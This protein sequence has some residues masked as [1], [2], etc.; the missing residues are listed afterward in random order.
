MANPVIVWRAATARTGGTVMLQVAEDLFREAGLD[1]ASIEA[2]ELND[3]FDQSSVPVDMRPAFFERYAGSI[4]VGGH[5]NWISAIFG[6]PL[7]R[8]LFVRRDLREAA[9]SL[10]RLNGAEIGGLEN[11]IK[12]WIEIHRLMHEL[13]PDHCLAVDYA[14]VLD[15]ER[16]ARRIA[17]Y[18]ALEVGE[19][20]IGR[21]AATYDKAALAGSLARA[22][23]R[24]FH[25]LT[26]LGDTASDEKVRNADVTAGEAT[27]RIRLPVDHLTPDC[28]RRIDADGWD[29]LSTLDFDLP[30]S[31]RISLEASADGR[32]LRIVDMKD[33]GV[34]D[35]NAD[36]VRSA[37]T[38]P[39]ETAFSDDEIDRINRLTA[40][41]RRTFGY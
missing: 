34:G 6:H 26:A 24:I 21:I 37:E 41:F 20:A 29:R 25:E 10:R 7:V 35:F 40:D 39:W 5:D 4:V 1:I 12:G 33:A 23:Q 3:G 11:L 9:A 13:I 18:F 32:T 19:D 14:E 17:A 36:H 38:P 30:E 22:R 8:T 28:A 31:G 27:A 15:I 16:M 2:E